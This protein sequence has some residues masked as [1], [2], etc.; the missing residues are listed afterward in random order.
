[1]SYKT[2]PDYTA[3]SQAVITSQV[4]DSEEGSMAYAITE[5]TAWVLQKTSA[6]AL[7]SN[8]IATKSGVGRWIKVALSTVSVPAY[9]DY[10][11]GLALNGSA[12]LAANSTPNDSLQ[13]S[14]YT[15]NAG[16]VLTIP[17]YALMVSGTLTMAAGAII[18]ADGTSAAADSTAGAAGIGPGHLGSTTSTAG[19]S[20]GSAGASGSNAGG[21]TRTIGGTGGNGG[22]NG[23]RTGGVAGP[24]G[25]IA[26]A[27][28]FDVPTLCWRATGA[29]LSLPTGGTPGAGGAGGVSG[30]GGGGGSG[31]CLCIVRA[32]SISVA[33]GALFRARGGA[34]G[35]RTTSDGSG[36]GGGGGGVFI[37]ICNTFTMPGGSTYSDFFNVSGGAGGTSAGGLPGSN[38]N[39]G[40]VRLYVGGVVVYSLN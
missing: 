30:A 28:V 6:D 29:S 10:L 38:G 25:S 22:N 18:S 33:A 34:G 4:P 3:T 32:G 36:G 37:V 26:N 9:S 27:G 2:V 19:S 24:A 39:A 17:N 14:A 35:N 20:G 40:K 23:P 5:K 31:G 12:T 8:V 7:G 16:I 13:Y 11:Y 15:I 21:S 1:L